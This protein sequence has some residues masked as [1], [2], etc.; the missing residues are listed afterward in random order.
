MDDAFITY[1]YARHLGE[2]FGPFWNL[3]GTPWRPVEGYSSLLH[4]VVLAAAHA[5]TGVEVEVLGK[6]LGLGFLFVSL[7]SAALLARRAGLSEP[8]TWLILVAFCLPPTIMAAA[9]GMETPLFLLFAWVMPITAIALVERGGVRDVPVL[10]VLALLGTLTRPEFALNGLALF[11]YVA[12]RRPDVRPALVRS[13]LLLYVLPGVAVTIWRWFTYQDVVPNP[14]YVKQ[15]LPGLLGVNYVGR[16]LVVCCLP[17]IA[18]ILPFARRLWIDRRDLV[19]IVAISVCLPCLYFITVRPIMG[20]WF[21][22]L[23]PHLPILAWLAAVSV[24]SYPATKRSAATVRVAT[25]VLFLFSLAQVP[26]IIWFVRANHPNDQRMVELGRR[27]R[28]LASSDRSF[29]YYDVGRLPYTSEWNV[30]DVIGLTTGREDLR[31]DCLNGTDLVLGSLTV[32]HTAV[33]KEIRNPC[34]AIYEPL[35]DLGWSKSPT[36]SRHMT[37]FARRDLA[38]R[39]ALR[40]ALLADWPEPDTPSPDWTA[41]YNQVLGDWFGR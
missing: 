37:I 12:W 6:L 14:F 25:I 5:A 19:A 36:Q 17:F 22:F 11:A 1:R 9:S 28:P 24:S 38:Y 10:V 21:R 3:P 34:P 41:T 4:M 27:L 30:L 8:G 29:S 26:S 13:V 31:G 35:V 40:Q 33:S 18:V 20:S 39:D 23:I 16:F 15:R 32:S 7:L 2:G